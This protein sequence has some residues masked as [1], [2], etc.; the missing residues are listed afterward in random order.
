MCFSCKSLIKIDLSDDLVL[1]IFITPVPV[2]KPNL[3]HH[4]PAFFLQ[5][6]C[7]PFFQIPLFS[8]A[9]CSSHPVFTQ[10]LFN[11]SLLV[12]SWLRG[13]VPRL[14][15]AAPPRTAPTYPCKV[16]ACTVMCLSLQRTLEKRIRVTITIMP[17]TST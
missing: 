1:L 9:L 5:S 13:K 7:V 11:F 16:H 17:R 12:R 3:F 4:F 8:F 6:S 15:L 10:T 2:L 14:Q